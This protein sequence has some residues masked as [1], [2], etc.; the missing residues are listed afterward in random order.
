VLPAIDP[1]TPALIAAA[2]GFRRVAPQASQRSG[3]APWLDS[4]AGVREIAMTLRTE[5]QALTLESRAS[6]GWAAVFR[7]VGPTQLPKAAPSG[8]GDR[9]DTVAS[10]AMGGVDGGAAGAVA[11]NGSTTSTRSLACPGH[12]P[13]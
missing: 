4:W 9:A 6:D 3:L 12:T 7:Y 2:L 5:H 1:V 10:G 13:K 8:L 11:A